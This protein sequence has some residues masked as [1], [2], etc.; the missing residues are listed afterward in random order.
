MEGVRKIWLH[1]RLSRAEE[2]MTQKTQEKA[3]EK[4]GIFYLAENRTRLLDRSGDQGTV[5]VVACSVNGRMK[6]NSRQAIRSGKR[7]E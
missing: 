7:G 6:R 4:A 3:T 2:N 5:R 1:E